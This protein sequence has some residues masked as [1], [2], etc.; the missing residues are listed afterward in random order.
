MTEILLS[1]IT[2]GVGLILL[3]PFGFWLNNKL[4]Q[5]KKIAYPVKPFV[6]SEYY[7]RMEK[8]SLEIQE[9][10]EKQEKYHITLWWG[11]DGL[12]LY[13]DGTTKWISRRKQESVN[14]NISYTPCQSQVA[15]PFSSLS[16]IAQ[17]QFALN[18]MNSFSA[19]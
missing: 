3:A 19:N 5:K 14:Q 10:Q 18:Y 4:D 1:L 17:Y 16:S 2:G 9:E 7:E 15:S 13:D 12:R 6:L 11:L 8:V